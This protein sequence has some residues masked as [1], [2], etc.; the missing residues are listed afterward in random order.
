MGCIGRPTIT[1][2]RFIFQVN[3]WTFSQRCQEKQLHAYFK[4]YKENLLRIQFGSHLPICKLTSSATINK[5]LTDIQ[6]RVPP[7]QDGRQELNRGFLLHELVV[8]LMDRDD[9]I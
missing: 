4:V 9:I 6:E 1:M 2:V 3:F 7:V 8:H 5:S